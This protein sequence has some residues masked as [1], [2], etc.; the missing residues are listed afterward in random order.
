MSEPFVADASVAVAW[1]HPA[2]ATRATQA[3]LQSVADGAMV[4]IPALWSV[5]VANALLVLTRRRKLREEER[6]TAL[7]WLQRLPVQVDH[8][9]S[10]LAFTNLSEHAAEYALSVYDAVYLELAR[11]RNLPLGCKDG[12]LRKAARKCGV[13]LW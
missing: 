6:R 11:R 3:M 1:I 10:S 5:E 2:Q 9:M 12:P 4:E 7:G 13:K 8:D